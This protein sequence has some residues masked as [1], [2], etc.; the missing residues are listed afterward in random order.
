MLG[1]NPV[2]LKT[3]YY[4]K[5]ELK[6]KYGVKKSLQGMKDIQSYL[7]TDRHDKLKYYL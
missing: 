5:S 2:W 4:D 6:N 7:N 1:P 3:E